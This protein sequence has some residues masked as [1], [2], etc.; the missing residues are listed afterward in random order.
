MKHN[1][2]PDSGKDISQVRGTFSPSVQAS[3]AGTLHKQAYRGWFFA[4]QLGMVLTK[5]LVAGSL[6]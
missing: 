4:L 6:A 5:Q 3:L 2:P 1:P